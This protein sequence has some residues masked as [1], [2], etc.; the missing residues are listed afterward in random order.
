MLP[1]GN[2]NYTLV[3]VTPQQNI[4]QKLKIDGVLEG[5]PNV[6][7]DIDACNELPPGDERIQCWADFDRKIMEEVV[8]W[9]PYLDATNV[10]IISEAVTKYEYDQFSGEAGFA[11]VAVDAT[12]QQ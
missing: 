4:E 1:T 6:D 10:D 11:H 5:I 3:G 12:Q 8:P 2:T 9:V 7:A